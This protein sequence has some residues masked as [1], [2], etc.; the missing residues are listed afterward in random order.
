VSPIKHFP[1]MFAFHLLFSSITIISLFV[2]AAFILS[3][4]TTTKK[5]NT[6]NK[7]YTYLP[8]VKNCTPYGSYSSLSKYRNDAIR[9]STLSSLFRGGILLQQYTIIYKF[10]QHINTHQLQQYTNIH[11]KQKKKKE[12]LNQLLPESTKKD[13]A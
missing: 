3:Y 6:H 7:L 2:A 9:S 8:E 13:T 4:A 11:N 5:K 1:P 10:S 12:H